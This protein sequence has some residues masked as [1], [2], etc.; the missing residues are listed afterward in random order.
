MRKDCSRVAVAL[1]LVGLVVPRSLATWSIAITNT[2]TGEVALG[3]A[4]CLE[5]IDLKTLTAVMAVGAGAGATQSIAPPGNY[6]KLLFQEL[7]RGTP[8]YLI[9]E[10]MQDLGGNDDRRQFGVADIV[11]RSTTFTGKYCSSWAGGRAGRVGDMSYAI[12][13]NILTGEPVVAAAE[14]AILTTPGDL[15]ERLMAGMEAARVQGGDSRCTVYGK[16]SHVG[17]MVVSRMGDIDA[18]CNVG[19]DCANGTYYL[20]F[21]VAFRHI[22]DPDPVITR[23]LLFQQWRASLVGRPDHLRTAAVVEPQYVPGDGQA[24]TTLRLALADW[25]GTLITH[26]GA[27]VTVQHHQSSAG[28]STIGPVVDHGDGTYSVPLTAGTIT[29][30][31]VFDVV[32][33]DGISPVTLYPYPSLEVISALRLRGDVTQISA[34]NGDDVKFVLQGSAPFAG[35]SYLLLMSGSGTAPGF[36]HGSVHVP[37]NFDGL[38]VNS[39]MLANIPPFVKTEGSLDPNARADASFAPAPGQLDPLVGTTLSF[40]YLSRAPDDFASPPVQVLIVP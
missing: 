14:F 36:D 25:Q 2:R 9:V 5:G 27:T 40:A 39:V 26:G 7:H 10:L 1:V 31:D 35:R 17:Y 37:L 21:N 24:T 16:S 3:C 23:G 6:R 30:T 38:L 22:P 18:A 12:Q 32:V 20:D 28:S 15:A 19:D 13:G 11:R 34:A 8:P 29:G 4:T 33:N